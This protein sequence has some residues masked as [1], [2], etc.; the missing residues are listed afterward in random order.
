MILPVAMFVVMSSYLT[1]LFTDRS[2]ADDVAVVYATIGV[3]L[4]AVNLWREWR[5]GRRGGP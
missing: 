4:T 1:L 5:H 3:S 2:A